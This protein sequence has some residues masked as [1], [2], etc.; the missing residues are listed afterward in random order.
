MRSSDTRHERATTTTYCV[1]VASPWLANVHARCVD[2]NISGQESSVII[3]R[4]ESPPTHSERSDRLWV[5]YI[6]CD[7]SGDCGRKSVGLGSKLAHYNLLGWHTGY[8]CV[9]N[10]WSARSVWVGF[11][12]VCFPVVAC[13]VSVADSD[14]LGVGLGVDAVCPRRM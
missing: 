11:G 2:A 10:G 3:W 7:C 14:F 12:V 5:V 13:G 4:G 1:G 9:G 8:M 6:K